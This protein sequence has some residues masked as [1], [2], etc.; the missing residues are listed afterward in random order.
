MLQGKIQKLDE[1]HRLSDTA[2]VDVNK[3]ASE[4]S[5]EKKQ[6][7]AP[8]YTQTIQSYGKGMM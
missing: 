4:E 2:T 5:G 1:E 6:E 3:K 7:V 8:L